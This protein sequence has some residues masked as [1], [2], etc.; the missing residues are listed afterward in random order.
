[1]NEEYIQI[2]VPGALPTFPSIQ[3]SGD[4]GEWEMQ[5]TGSVVQWKQP[6]L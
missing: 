3:L 5:R 6:G 2:F 1:M 4:T